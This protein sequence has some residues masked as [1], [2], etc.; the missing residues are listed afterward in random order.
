MHCMWGWSKSCWWQ[1]LFWV[2]HTNIRV[3]NSSKLCYL[4]TT[5]LYLFYLKKRS[6][7][8]KK[9][10]LL[11]C[12][13]SKSWSVFTLISFKIRITTKRRRGK[14][15]RIAK[16][17]G[18][19]KRPCLLS[20]ERNEDDEHLQPGRVLR[21]KSAPVLIRGHF[22]CPS[23]CDIESSSSKRNWMESV[24]QRRKMERSPW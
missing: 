15:R 2:S 23:F 16:G 11:L 3:N 20:K 18:R 6:W 19:R 4:A 22:L 9:T 12:R 7:L 13:W 21:R 1:L 17:R 5:Q 24:C 14:E 10:A 8:F